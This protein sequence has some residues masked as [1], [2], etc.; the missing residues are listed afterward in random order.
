MQ[1]VDQQADRGH[2]IALTVQQKVGEEGGET[3]LRSHVQTLGNL[4]SATAAL[5]DQE[6]VW[7]EM[8]LGQ[9]EVRGWMSTTTEETTCLICEL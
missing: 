5:L 8:Q 1:G 3:L 6:A 4:E 9:E 7:K 2:L